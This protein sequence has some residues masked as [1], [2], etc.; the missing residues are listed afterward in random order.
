VAGTAAAGPPQALGAIPPRTEK[1]GKMPSTDFMG[2]RVR[3]PLPSPAV[4]PPAESE[5]SDGRRWRR[6]G[7]K[8]GHHYPMKPEHQDRRSDFAACKQ[9]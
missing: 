6:R 1:G 5:G 9:K 2:C 8:Q 3:S 4:G 7:K